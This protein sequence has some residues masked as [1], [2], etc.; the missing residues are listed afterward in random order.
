MK[1]FQIGYYKYLTGASETQCDGDEQIA[2]WYEALYQEV[3]KR[4]QAHRPG[5][6]PAQEF[7]DAPEFSSTEESAIELDYEWIRLGC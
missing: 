3:V 4:S 6:F 2:G 7:E 5:L 1:D